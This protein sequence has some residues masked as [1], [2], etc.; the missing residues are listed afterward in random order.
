MRF[1]QRPL[2]EALPELLALAEEKALGVTVLACHACQ[3]LSDQVQK[4]HVTLSLG[5]ASACWL[6]LGVV[7]VGALRTMERYYC[8]DGRQPLLMLCMV[9]CR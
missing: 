7:A 8:A 4:T 9:A 3:H 6:P 5:P 1:D 2:M